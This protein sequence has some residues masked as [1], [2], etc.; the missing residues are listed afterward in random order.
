MQ[1]IMIILSSKRFPVLFVVLIAVLSFYAC[2]SESPKTAEV[3]VESSGNPAKDSFRRGV[4]YSLKGDHEKAVEEYKKSLELNPNSAVAYSNLGFE[5]YD[6]D[7]F[8]KSAE[9]QEKA[10]DINPEL[11][12]AFY[13]LAMALEKKGDKDGA[14]ENYKEFLSISET[15][16]LWWNNAKANI[17]RLERRYGDPFKES[18]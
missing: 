2:G 18:P 16:T 1:K 3:E 7:Q 4:Q 6:L 9:Y 5:Y 8:D 13:G 17:E 10:L 11:A 14:I 12:N 15:H